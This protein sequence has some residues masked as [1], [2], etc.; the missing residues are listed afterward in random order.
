M[1]MRPSPRLAF[2]A[3]MSKPRARIANRE[4]NVTGGSP[5]SHFEVPNP[6]VFGRIVKGFLQNS[7][8]GKENVGGRGAGQIVGSEINL[9]F[10]LLPEFLTEALSWPQQSQ[11]IAVV[12]SA[13]RATRTGHRRLSQRSASGVRRLRPR[14]SRGPSCS[15]CSPM[16]NS[17]IR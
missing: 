16:P 12:T 4:M 7:E 3:S 13:T 14:D 17:A 5:Q 9:H 1:L 15:S 11:D 8:E 2:A 10:L 6:T